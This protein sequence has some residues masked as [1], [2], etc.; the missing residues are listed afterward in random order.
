MYLRD[1]QG[2]TR[3]LLLLD[4]DGNPSIEMRDASSNVTWS[5]Q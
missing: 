3:I 4:A 2:Q 5:A 1:R